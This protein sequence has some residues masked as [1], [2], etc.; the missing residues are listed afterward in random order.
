LTQGTKGYRPLA[1][2][3]DVWIGTDVPA[4]GVALNLGQLAFGAPVSIS[5]YIA[6]TGDGATANWL[7]KLSAS[8]KEFNVP[9]KFDQSV[10]LAGLSNGC[11]NVASGVI[12]S[13]GS[14]CGTGGG[15]GVNSIIWTLGSGCGGQWRLHGVSIT[16]AAADAAVVHNTG[17]ET[18]AGAKTFTSN[19]H[20]EWELVIAAGEYFRPCRRRHRA[21]YSCRIACGEHCGTTHQV[22]LLVQILAGQAGTALALAA[23]P[24]QC[25]GSF[26]TGIAANGECELHNAQRDPVV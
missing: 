5:N 1:S 22:A 3:N 26:A 8:L 12:A 7:E 18:I 6:H 21:G 13:T 14:P 24:T 15:G 9:A 4:N 11:L 17:A 20:D 25:S 2:V 19:V 10:T 23:V 16:G